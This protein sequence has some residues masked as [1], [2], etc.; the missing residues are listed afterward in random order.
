VDLLLAGTGVRLWR[1]RAEGEPEALTSPD[2]AAGEKS[3]RRPSVLPGS[4]AVLFVVGT[5]RIDSFDS[6]RIEV[7]S[8]QDR[9]RHL[10]VLR[11]ATRQQD[12]LLP[13][14]ESPRAQGWALTRSSRPWVRAAWGRCIA[15]T[16]DGLA[17][18]SP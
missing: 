12:R 13:A 5:S 16:T 14:C 6:A 3:H 18:P 15:R 4:Q 9:R 11:S 2:L 7:L 1:V 17:D 10:V 8:L